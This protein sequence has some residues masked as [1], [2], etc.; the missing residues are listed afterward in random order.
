MNSRQINHASSRSSDLRTEATVSGHDRQESAPDHPLR[1]C[2][3]V[4]WEHRMRLVALSLLGG[5]ICL[6][7]AGDGTAAP[8]TSAKIP[9]EQE[10]AVQGCA[11]NSKAGDWLCIIIRCDNPKSPVSMHFSASGAEIQGNIELIIDKNIYAVSVPA[12]SKSPLPNA[13]RAQTLPSAV[14][15]AMKSGH[16]ISIRG[17]QLQAPY[18]QISL[19]NSR[20]AIESVE[21]M[22]SRSLSGP[23][24]F[25]RRLARSVGMY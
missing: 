9:G 24:I 7:S 12:S 3:T 19:E 15:A 10:R 22:C 21:R 8:W 6:A 18:N 5:C 25:W 13:T 23:A 11:D 2:L 20:P 14:F 17:S 16:T 1:S 4:M